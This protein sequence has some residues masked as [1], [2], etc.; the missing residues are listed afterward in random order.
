MNLRMEK[1]LVV[2]D[3]LIVARDI[4]K[5]LERNGYPGSG[6]SPIHR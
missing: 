6:C 4:K 1:I 2:E 3:E 5:T